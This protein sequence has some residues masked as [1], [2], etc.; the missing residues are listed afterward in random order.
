[1][2]FRLNINI[3]FF[4]HIRRFFLYVTPN[5]EKIVTHTEGVYFSK[6]VYLADVF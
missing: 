5:F 4:H 1:M 6:L 3:H 2:Q